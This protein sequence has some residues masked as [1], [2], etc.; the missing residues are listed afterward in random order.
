MDQENYEKEDA[1]DLKVGSVFLII[2]LILIAA[3][4]Y[5]KRGMGHPELMMVFHGPAA[6][7]L[8]MGGL[9]VSKKQR[10]RFNEIKIQ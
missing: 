3:G 5:V 1:A 2:F 10:R 7:F 8:V 4:V 6:I 9:K